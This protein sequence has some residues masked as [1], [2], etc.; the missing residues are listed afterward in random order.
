MTRTHP[1][2]TAVDKSLVV[3]V[4][5][6]NIMDGEPLATTQCWN[7]TSEKWTDLP[8]F[9]Y[10]VFSASAVSSNEKI[11]VVGGKHGATKE[12][13]NCLHVLD[14]K[15]EPRAWK[16]L[17]SMKQ[18]RRGCATVLVSGFIY[19]FGGY[20]Y[21]DGKEEYMRSVERYDI[22]SY[23]WH[24]VDQMSTARYFAAATAVGNNI[25][26]LGGQCDD[27]VTHLGKTGEVFNVE[28]Q[29]WSPMP[30]MASRRHMCAGLT[31]S[32]FV[33]VLGGKNDESGDILSTAEVFDTQKVE[34]LPEVIHT[35]KELYGFG[36]VMLESGKL[37]V[38]GGGALAGKAPN[39]VEFGLEDYF[40]D[41][42]RSSSP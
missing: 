14:L 31:L 2:V 17:A 28:T 18:P 11:Y 3:V 27:D 30:N 38:I 33:I 34:W 36:A 12:T 7:E 19:V 6:L 35:D 4:G 39:P 26:V 16:E 25:Y 13:K 1:A 9:P 20:N 5:G 10:P 29:S 32:E 24:C 41:L 40:K 8:V 23:E 21:Q 42:G 15:A 22:Q 37:V